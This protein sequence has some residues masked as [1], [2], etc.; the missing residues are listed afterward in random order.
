MDPRIRWALAEIDRNL[1][2][3]TLSELAAG[4]NL[5]PS[6]F[7]H[8]FTHD[9]GTSPARYLRMRRLDHARVL[10]E[11]TFLTVKEVMARVGLNDA[12]HFTRYFRQCHGLP[13]RQWRIAIHAAKLSKEAS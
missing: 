3:V 11:T 4:V 6:R 8:L 1:D 12:S 9:V 10:L 2:R 13:P 7:G 5:S